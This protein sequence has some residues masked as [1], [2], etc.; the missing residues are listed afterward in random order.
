MTLRKKMMMVFLICIMA[1][2]IPLLL[3]LNTRVK[4]LNV[5]QTQVQ[6]MELI[7]SKSTEIGFWLFQ[8]I[9]EIRII[10]EYA[11][12]YD[13]TPESLKPYLTKLNLTLS[14][15]YGNL[16]EIFAVGNTDGKGWINNGVTIDISNRDYFH[17][18]MNPN[19]T[20]YVISEP[21]ISRSDNEPIFVICYPMMNEK[22]EKTGFINGAVSLNKI[23]EIAEGIDVYDGFSWIMNKKGEVYSTTK[24]QLTKEYLAEGGLQAII[25]KSQE[26]NQSTLNL[27]N[28]QSKK[29]TVF[30][31]IIPYTEDW[32]L[33][34]L[35]DDAKLSSATDNIINLV[36]YF[37]I[38]MLGIAIL[39]TY[40][41][42]GHML[43]P[44]SS[45]K[46]HMEDVGKG[47][48]DSFYQVTHN[49]EISVLGTVFNKMVK[50]LRQ[51]IDKVYLVENQKRSAEL[52]ALQSQINPHFLYN[53]LD[54]IQWKALDHEAY[55]VADMIHELSE[56]F[57]ISLSDGREFIPVS[58]EIQHVRHYL[59][60]QVLRYQDQFDYEIQVE[61]AVKSLLIP[62][63]IIQPLVEN[64]IY[65]GLKL[66]REKGILFIQIKA[67]DPGLLITVE[68]NGVGIDELKLQ[69]IRKNLEHSRESEHYGLY[70]VNERL[71]L[72]FGEDYCITIDSQ[73]NKG[74]KI[75]LKLPEIKGDN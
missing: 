22:K 52:R 28:T 40:F 17:D 45:L 12:P 59:E 61:E 41:L 18:V 47:N 69:E 34:T 21:L 44:L 31:S 4:S 6:T 48:L 56:L 36:L 50:E 1:A 35:V 51:L 67:K 75:T 62:K 70:N 57:R 7:N 19:N 42:S 15:Q 54:T 33:C 72:A 25:Q 37:G 49:D 74:T 43:K 38:I 65:H 53:T 11:S 16:N 8:R 24:D 39:L 71:K 66:K 2:F 5:E 14:T 9:S 68:D 27:I 13:Y 63:I 64:A 3:I 55:D 60:I 26:T 23:S 58:T 32:L 30:F 46:D 29:S 20:T 73:K 10:H